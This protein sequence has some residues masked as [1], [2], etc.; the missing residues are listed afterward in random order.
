MA[1]GNTARTENPKIPHLKILVVDDDELNR[2]MMKILLTREGHDVDLAANGMDALDSVKYQRFDIVFM[3][4]QMPTMDG[5]EASRRIRQW[6]NGGRHTFIVALTAS[7]L[8]EEGHRLFEAGIDNYIAKPF[9]IEHIQRI[10]KLIS[11]TNGTVPIQPEPVTA[12]RVLGGNTLDL[13]KGIRRVGGDL[14]TFKELLQ[15]FAR[16][17]PHRMQ[18]LEQYLRERN[19][20]ALYRG[21]H[22][23]VGVASNLGALELAESASKLDKPSNE[24]YT[25]LHER[26]FVDLKKAAD[27]LIRTANDFFLKKE[28]NVSQV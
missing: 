11:K 28:T 26:L 9:E 12:N 21:A 19:L 25:P 20:E 6:E 23:L 5:V 15:D 18:I 17:L 3:D 13:Q 27:N 24:G 22:N 16:D 2:R 14:D 7:Y 8:P 10:L 4:L 1:L